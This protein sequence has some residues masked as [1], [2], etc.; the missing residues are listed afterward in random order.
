MVLP[1]AFAARLSPGFV[2]LATAPGLSTASSPATER[3]LERAIRAGRGMVK[4]T[5]DSGVGEK[6]RLGA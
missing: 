1:P 4:C 2:A 3:A 6:R 5:D